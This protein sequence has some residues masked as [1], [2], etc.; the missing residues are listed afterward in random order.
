MYI[1]T[2]IIYRLHGEFKSVT[3]PTV[4]DSVF[5]VLADPECRPWSIG[6][7]MEEPVG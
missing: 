3:L 6:W 7:Y 5:S 1:Q 4:S 2:Y